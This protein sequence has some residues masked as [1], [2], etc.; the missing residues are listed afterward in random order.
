M[1]H[2]FFQ[3]ED[4]KKK[5]ISIRQIFT[6]VLFRKEK[7]FGACHDIVRVSKNSSDA[8]R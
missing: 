1:D 8:F 2:C 4:L 6:K 7:I 5:I 3:H